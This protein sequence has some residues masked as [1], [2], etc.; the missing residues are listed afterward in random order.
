MVRIVFVSRDSYN[1]RF[2]GG[3]LQAQRFTKMVAPSCEVESFV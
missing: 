2:D 1:E 3:V